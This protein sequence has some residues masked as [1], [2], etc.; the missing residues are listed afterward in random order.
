MATQSRMFTVT[1]SGSA[2]ELLE[3]LAKRRG[4]S[5]EQV[6]SE[7]LTVMKWFEDTEHEKGTQI[8]VQR[9]NDIRQIKLTSS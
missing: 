3:E 5:K 7:A 2:Y 9:G 1:I 6:I 4:K 8:L